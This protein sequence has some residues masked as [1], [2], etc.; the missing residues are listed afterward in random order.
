MISGPRTCRLRSRNATPLGGDTSESFGFWLRHGLSC[1][2]ADRYLP[3]DLH[4]SEV[5]RAFL[6]AGT[7]PGPPLMFI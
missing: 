1:W 7:L 4:L 5:T 3:C 2:L 6:I